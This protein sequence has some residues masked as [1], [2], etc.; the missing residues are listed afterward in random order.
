VVKKNRHLPD[1]YLITISFVP[2]INGMAN[3]VSKSDEALHELKEAALEREAYPRS[4]RET[5]ICPGPFF[6]LLRSFEGF[7]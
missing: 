6:D 1:S 2:E 5:L 7:V 4:G 3:R